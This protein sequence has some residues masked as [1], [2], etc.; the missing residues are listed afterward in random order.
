M[1][2]Q[3][4]I[5]FTTTHLNNY[6]RWFSQDDLQHDVELVVLSATNTLHDLERCHGFILTG[7]VDIHPSLYNGEVDYPHQPKQFQ[8]DRDHFEQQLF[9]FAQ[10]NH[11]PV[12]GICR[13]LQLVNVLQGGSLVQ[14]LGEEHNALHKAA[15]GDKQH[16]VIL[17]AGSMLHQITGALSGR[18]NSAHHQVM[19][20]EKIGQNLKATAW[21]AG[22]QSVIEAIE[23]ENPNDKP[24]LLCVQWHP[25]RME[26]QTSVFSKNIKYH[27]LQ[28]VRG[29]ITK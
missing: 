6:V 9:F 5:S 29:A 23:W 3:I 14:D 27:F 21:S 17:A 18:V 11:K 25:E 7:G 19:H 26:D 16:E 2:K 8:L 1:K 20:S 4:G 13:G 22:P 12:L 15:E 24:F 10:E 28:I